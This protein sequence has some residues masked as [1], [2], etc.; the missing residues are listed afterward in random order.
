[1]REYVYAYIY[2]YIYVYIYI[3]IWMHMYVC[4]LG[5]TSQSPS[6][7][8][9]YGNLNWFPPLLT[10]PFRLALLDLPLRAASAV[11]SS[12]TRHAYVHSAG[13]GCEKAQEH[14]RSY[15]RQASRCGERRAGQDRHD[16][17]RICLNSHQNL[18]HRSLKA[19][20]EHIQT[21]ASSRIVAGQYLYN[22]W[23]L[24]VGVVWK[25]FTNTYL[26][27]LDR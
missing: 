26:T 11:S 22:C 3:Y 27:L 5:M 20:D 2:I 21:H 10:P 23:G 12:S 18:R 19:F 17:I 6:V 14:W 4:N 9:E 7:Q 8:N 13:V 15:D 25:L 16:A 24:G 1:M